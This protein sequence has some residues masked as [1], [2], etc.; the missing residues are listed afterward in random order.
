MTSYSLSAFSY[1]SRFT[2]CHRLLVNP[3]RLLKKKMRSTKQGNCVLRYSIQPVGQ[4]KLK[5]YTKTIAS[6]GEINV[7]GRRF[8]NHS[9][10]KTTVRKLQKSGVSNDKI[11]CIMGH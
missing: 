1:N 3:G 10:H 2:K 5:T 9:I 8:T 11:A 4:G 6:M 7:D